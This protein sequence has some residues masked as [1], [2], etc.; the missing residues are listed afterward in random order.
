ML[1]LTAI[2]LTASLAAGTTYVVARGTQS[3]P[4]QAAATKVARSTATAP[5]ARSPLFGAFHAPAAAHPAP[6]PAGA[7]AITCTETAAHMVDMAFA[8]VTDL[9]PAG[10]HRDE[11]TAFVKTHFEDSCERGEWS[12][13][14]MA[15]VLG[16]PDSYSMMLDCASYDKPTLF[17]DVPQTEGFGG[18]G[19]IMLPSRTEPIAPTTDTSCAGIAK[20]M[21]E[22]S[23]PDPADLAKMSATHPKLEETIAGATRSMISQVEKSCV[24]TAWPD[25]RRKCL[26]AATTAPAMMACQ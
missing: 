10:P 17:D 13:E 2:A 7:P 9:P 18:E 6:R 14:Y 12:Q 16:S 4:Q 21:S 20:H 3:S 19:E 22:L 15:C 23:M 8:N 25:A 5:Q 26:A 24:D 11:A 1:K